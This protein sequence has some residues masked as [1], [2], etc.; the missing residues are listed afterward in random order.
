M[1]NTVIALFED[2]ENAQQAERYLLEQGFIQSDINLK[3][4]VYKNQHHEDEETAHTPDLLDS[5]TAF[6]KDLFGNDHKEVA[7]YVAASTHRTILTVHTGT[8]QDAERVS[9][10]LDQYGAISV[11]ETAG[12]YAEDDDNQ[13]SARANAIKSRIIQRATNE[14]GSF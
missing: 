4:A 1:A 6:F 5:I 7:T 3:T 13:T 10:I 14:R 12:S 8:D 2:L 11:G 9:G